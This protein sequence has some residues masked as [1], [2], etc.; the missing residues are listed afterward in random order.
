M[1]VN[2]NQSYFKDIKFFNSVFDLKSLPKDNCKEVAFAGR[3]NCGKSSL[4]N[5]IT[6]KNL[7][8]TSKTPG[9]TKSINY[10]Q[11]AEHKYL[12]DLPGYGYAKVPEQ[13]KKFWAQLLEQ[14]LSIRRSLVGI[15]LIMDIRHPLKD[16][17]RQMLFFCSLN[18]LPLHIVLN[19]TDKL[20]KNQINSTIKA[21]KLELHN[22][23][24]LSIQPFSAL[25]L[26][27]VKELQDQIIKW[28]DNY[29]ERIIQ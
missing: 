21:V 23:P 17:D 3:S 12:V 2:S 8:I 13:T 29:T 15:V 14:Y 4:I 16:F 7:A 28:L 10:F 27:G 6:K 9:R 19:K 5:A 18:N 22:I 20:T 1:C 11:L 25:K 26:H 24:N